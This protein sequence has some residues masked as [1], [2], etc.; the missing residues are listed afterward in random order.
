M[1]KPKKEAL[2]TVA[3]IPDKPKNKNYFGKET[4]IAI[5]EFQQETDI[6]KRNDIFTK[7]IKPSFDK[8]IENLINVY[9][10]HI[11]GDVNEL[12]HDSMTFLFENLYK[13]DGTRGFKA[14]SY[15]NVIG[16]NWFIL[17]LKIKKKSK[18]TTISINKEIV[19]MIENDE[20]KM[21]ESYEKILFDQQFIKFLKEDIDGW[22]NKFKKVQEKKVLEAIICLIND[23]DCIDIYSKKGILMYI[24]EYTGLNTKQ[25]V[26]SFMKMRKKYVSF[27]EQYFAGE[28][29]G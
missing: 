9:K 24:R 2:K 19:E 13:F 4:E 7:R 28:L 10:F 15:F 14:F 3:Q 25:I 17:K 29:H 5:I 26:N 23:P 20:N 12:K 21:V 27:K 16:K 18:N 1:P 22:Q 11:I 6:K 8:L